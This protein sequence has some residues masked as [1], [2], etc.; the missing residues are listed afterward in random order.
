MTVTVPRMSRTAGLVLSSA[1]V[2]GVCGALTPPASAQQSPAQSAP[3]QSAPVA[4]S[5]G[6]AAAAPMVVTPAAPASPASG[7]AKDAPKDSSLKPAEPSWIAKQ[8]ASLMALFAPPNAASG[9]QSQSQA[10]AP[11]GPPPTVS[12][13]RPVTRELVEWDE[14]TGRL[15]AVDTVEIRAR[16][17]GYLTDVHFK[18]GQMVKKGDVLYTLDARPFERALDQAKAEF[19]LANTRIANASKDVVRAQPLLRNR[20]ITEKTFDDRQNLYEDAEAQAKVAD[21]KVKSA[22]LDLSFTK[23]YAPLTGRISRSNVSV[24]NYVIGGAQVSTL[25]TNVV[26]QDPI[27]V[28]FDVSENNLIKYKRFAGQGKSVGATDIGMAV[29]IALP[30]ET[31]F[32]HSGKLDFVDNRLDAGTG[33]L[34][35]RAL[36]DNPKGLF[37]PGMF[38][39]VRISGSTAYSA[40]LVPDEAIGTDQSDRFVYVVADDGTATRRKVTVGNLNDGLRIVRAGLTSEDWVIVRGVQRARP[41][42]KV[43]PNREPI[44]VSTGP[45]TTG[46]APT[47]AKP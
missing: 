13:S 27:Q 35:V 3:A 15:D 39:R 24:G 36:L 12:V 28:Y 8:W 30:D 4:S 7:T 33:T 9:A 18:D 41:G 45:E 2:L 26:T 5:S 44:K 25:L 19:G 42:Q 32:P 20:F 37:S 29:A 38:A 22:E 21:A 17:S 14:Y 16:V 10:K 23:I 31:N 11:S 6:S 47:V 46:S 1:T 34:R 43:T 40:M